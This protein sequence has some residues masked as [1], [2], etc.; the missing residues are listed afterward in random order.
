MTVSRKV[1]WFGKTLKWGCVCLILS[2]GL[3]VAINVVD[4]DLSPEANALLE[5]P[6][7]KAEPDNGYL[8]YAGIDA[9][10]NEDSFNYGKQWVETY[11]AAAD[12]RALE[13]ANTRFQEAGLS[14]R[15]NEKLCKPARNPCLPQAKENADLWRKLAADNEILLSRHQLLAKFPNFEEIAFPASAEAPLLR[16]MVRMN[17]HSLELDMI[18]LDVAEGRLAPAL[19]ALENRIAFDRRVLLGSRTLVMGMVATSG[20]M[21]DYAILAE[22]VATRASGL[23]T[24]K[25]RLVRMTE[26]LEVRQIRAIAGRLIEGE[27]RMII[28]HISSNPLDGMGSD[29]YSGLKPF[30]K[31]RA[32]QNLFTRH[33]SSLQARVMEFTPENS[34]LWL[35]KATQEGQSWIDATIH[36]WRILYNPVGKY[37]VSVGMNGVYESYVPRLSSLIAI[38]RLARLQVEVVTDGIDDTGIPTRI[39]ANKELYDPYTG[40]PMGWDPG[41]R[42]LY[43]DTHDKGYSSSE[44]TRRVQ[45]GI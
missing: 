11:N 31:P 42:Q 36:S 29:L 17:L 28:R 10:D 43:F 32:T 1:S 22:I 27:H 37:G 26:Q 19:D 4:E 18:A 23:A 45:A 15:G 8:A 21:E 2:Y 33:Y 25:A 16:Y 20:L 14:F 3:L 6:P 41:K 39:A 44:P 30:F 13:K 9:P 24:E 12:K 5:L 7:M 35:D 40:K 38:T 34:D